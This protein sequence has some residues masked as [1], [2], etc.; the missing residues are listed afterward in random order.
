M[1]KH[2]L[3]FLLFGILIVVGIISVINGI[4]GQEEQ[5]IK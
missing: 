2:S 4:Y 5:E 1:E 3:V